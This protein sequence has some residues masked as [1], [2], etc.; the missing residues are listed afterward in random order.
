MS[1]WSAVWGVADN[2]QRLALIALLIA[3]F[4]QTCFIVVYGTRPWYRSRVGRALMLKSASL[5][6]VLWLTVVNTFF[7][8]PLEEQLSTLGLTLVSVAIVYQF[9]VMVSTPRTV[10]VE[11]RA[12]PF[13]RK[14]SP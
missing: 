12:E 1:H 10:N 13:P 14:E 5:A 11:P 8:Y 7:I 4:A 2:W 6:V 3:T 9:L